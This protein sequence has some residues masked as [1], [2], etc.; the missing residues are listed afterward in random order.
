MSKIIL[1]SVFLFVCIFSNAQVGIGTDLPNSSAQL[2]VESSDRGI[3]IPRIQLKNLIDQETITSGNVQSLLVFNTNK[4]SQLVPGYYYWYAG[5]WRKLL[6]SEEVAEETNTSIASYPDG[7]FIYTNESGNE[8]EFDANTVSYTINPDG[9]YTFTN[10]NNESLTINVIGDVVNDIE[11]EGAVY[12]EIIELLTSNS[13][14][15]TDLGEGKFSHTSVDGTAVD[16]D[17]NTVSYT[18]DVNN[19]YVFTNANGE[20]VT[21]EVIGDVVNDIENEGAVYDEIIEL[22]TSNS[23]VFTD[24]GEGKFSHTSVDGTAVDFDANTVSYTRDVNNNYVFTNAN[25]EGVTVEV[26]GDVVNDIENE[27]AV[28]DEIIELL[29]SNSDVFTDLGEGKFSHTSVDGTA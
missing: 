26:I 5:R 9:S 22:L 14:V 23:D 4:T 24:L 12:D 20:G 8:V 16:F 19:N 6:I 18:R 2:D 29:T 3:L 25:G 17:A 1:V 21:V 7:T 10:D 15:F 28:Y 11:N 27:G 13:D